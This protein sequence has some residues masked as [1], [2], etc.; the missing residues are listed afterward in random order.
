MSEAFETIAVF[1]K[2]VGLPEKLIRAM[3]R[4][5]QLSHV[6]TGPCHARICVAAALDELRKFAEQTAEQIAMRMP[7]PV[8][9]AKSDTT[10]SKK[11]RG[12]PPDKVRLA[13]KAR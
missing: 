9:L 13:Q 5:G 6:K 2:R 8:Y 4:Q 7:V 1:A 11:R 12:R 3:V 10:G